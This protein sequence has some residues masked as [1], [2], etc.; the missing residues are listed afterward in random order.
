MGSFGGHFFFGQ[1]DIVYY[2]PLK[3]FFNATSS[4]GVRDWPPL[5]TAR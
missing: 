2:L 4:D 3:Y 1:Q 5:V